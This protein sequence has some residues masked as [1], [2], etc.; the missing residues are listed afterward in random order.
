M[1]SG[2]ANKLDDPDKMA[3]LLANVDTYKVT[4][5]VKDDSTV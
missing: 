4:Y 1:K 5:E 3:Q 2:N